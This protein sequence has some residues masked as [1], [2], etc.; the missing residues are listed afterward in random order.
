MSSVLE[1]L[2]ND[3]AIK[4][5]RAAQ[6]AAE[7]RKR[8]QARN[9]AE[10]RAA[11]EGQQLP[12]ALLDEL[13]AEFVSRT[14]GPTLILHYRGKQYSKCQLY[15]LTTAKIVDW[16]EQV[17]RDIAERERKR[18]AAHDRLTN[19]ISHAGSFRALLQLR[20]DVKNLQFDDLTPALDAREAELHAARD[21]EI[22][23]VVAQVEAATDHS[24]LEKIKW[25]Y[26]NNPQVMEA[27]DAARQR[28]HQATAER[29]ERRLQAQQAAF[30]SYRVWQLEYGIVAEDNGENWV[31]TD[32]I[33]TTEPQP[34]GQGFF[35]KPSGQLV[36]IFNPVKATPLDIVEPSYMQ[37]DNSTWVETEW[38]HIRIPP[39]N[40]RKL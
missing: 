32:S 4:R 12:V 15:E 11:I 40:C 35:V 39:D 24:V 21:A 20:T 22:A 23:Q 8:E 27:L 2:R 14:G 7:E 26:P 1:Q 30:F 3:I 17:D 18:A 13:Q 19:S 31:E 34:N 38:G 28:L 36:Y 29:E 5:E 33:F 25:D 16:T 6:A 10:F 37:P 9:L